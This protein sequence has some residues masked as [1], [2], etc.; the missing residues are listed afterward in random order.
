MN[1]ISPNTVAE[2]AWSDDEQAIIDVIHTETKAFTDRN[3]PLWASCF[4]Q[5]ERTRD[6]YISP[7]TGFEV[8]EGWD[9]IRAQMERVFEF[10]ISCKITDFG[11]EN[12]Q[13]SISGGTA[14]VVFDGWSVDDEN[15][16]ILS[17]ETRVLELEDDEWK[18]AYT[19]FA[20][21][22][23]TEEGHLSVAVDKNGRILRASPDALDALKAHDVIC[24]SAGRLRAK[25]QVWD[26]ELQR[27]FANA[28]RH[29]GFFDNF[30]FA[31]EMGGPTRFPVILGATDD[32]GVAYVTFLIRDAVTYV[33]VGKDDGMDKRMRLAQTVFSLSENQFNVARR[34]AMGDSMKQA[35]TTLGVSPNTARTHLAR[36]YEKTGVNSQ[37]ALVRLLL[38]VG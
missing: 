21:T 26:K 17:F 34:I 33:R 7:T 20:Q 29:H 3:M 18:I 28:A 37:A 10:N 11:Q 25:R 23:D 22:L 24:V 4:V 31:N 15:R 38:S 35:A 6:V 27:A 36:L 13:I 9:A 19:S 14:W 16:R 2:T 5:D 1:Q 8:V 32:G 12:F 30:R